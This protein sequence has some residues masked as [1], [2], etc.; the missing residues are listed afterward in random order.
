MLHTLNELKSI[1]ADMS[2]DTARISPSKT[3]SGGYWSSCCILNNFIADKTTIPNH[4]NYFC[5]TFQSSHQLGQ[6]SYKQKNSPK[7]LM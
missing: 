4:G 2:S 7:A 6:T 5:S 3:I 1:Q